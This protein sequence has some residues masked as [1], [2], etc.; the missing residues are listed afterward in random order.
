MP[1][2][3]PYRFG[4]VMEQTLGHVTHYR[5]LRA[6]VD[7]DPEVQ[8][9][10]L[11][12]AFAPRG[13]LETLPLLRSNW[14]ARASVRARRLLRQCDATHTLDAVL[15][16]TQVPTLLCAGLIRQIPTVISLDATPRNYD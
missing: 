12:L 9:T 10:W 8:A 16:H 2:Q 11:P 6:T 4:F 7:S 5:N 3:R 1:V 15:F 14:S 13:T